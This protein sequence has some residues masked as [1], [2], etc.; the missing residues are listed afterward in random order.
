MT[1]DRI[2]PPEL[3]RPS[4]FAHAVAGTGR[5]VFLAGQ[6]AQDAA[7]RIIP[8]NIVAQ[9][10]RALAN[11]LTALRAAGGEPEQLAALT[12]YIVDVDDYRAHAAEIGAVWRRLAGSQYPAT[13][14]VGVARLWDPTALV[15]LQGIALLPT[16]PG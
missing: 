9:F 11:L 15:E 3:P 10:E 12:I 7:G 4:G 6:T 13:A 1:L 2:D 8:G 5:T 14:G 16:G